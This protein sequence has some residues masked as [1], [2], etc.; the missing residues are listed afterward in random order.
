MFQYKY[1][2]QSEN[3]RKKTFVRHLRVDF[4]VLQQTVTDKQ[5]LL[6]LMWIL[7]PI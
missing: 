1:Y 5:Q 7:T 4:F 3:E 6:I 2:L